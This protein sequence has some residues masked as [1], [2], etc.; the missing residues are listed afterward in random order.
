MRFLSLGAEARWW[1]KPETRPQK[2]RFVQRDRLMGHFLGV[3]AESGKWDF[4]WGRKICHQGEHWSAG[5]SYGYSMPL[6]RRLN[7]ELSLSAGYASIPYRKFEP[8]EDYEIL[9]RDPEKVGRW[10]YFGPTKAQVS[11]VYPILLTTK[12]K[13]GHR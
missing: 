10:H 2:E 1:V 6:G 3:Y 9:W 8:S 11:L 13:G 5:I 4:E 7:M 12:K